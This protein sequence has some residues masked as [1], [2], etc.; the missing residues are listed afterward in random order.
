VLLCGDPHLAEDLTQTTYAKVFV[1]WRR[2][3][4]ADDPVAYTRAVL[5]RT[6]L[7]HRRRR[8]ASEVPV[9][10][11]PETPGATDDASLR[12]DLLAALARLAPADRTVLV[13]RY[14]ED[15]SVARTAELLGIK[16]T[17]CRARSSRAVARLRTHLPDLE[18]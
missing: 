6:Y 11:P 10:A 16:E 2:V 13:L 15:L 18:A 17:T 1:H 8:S 14:W 9:D 3:A 7:S 4:R 12:L 5:V